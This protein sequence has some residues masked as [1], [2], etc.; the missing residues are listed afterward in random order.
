MNLICCEAFWKLLQTNKDKTVGDII[1]L[2]LDSA[3]SRLNQKINEVL[4]DLF[5]VENRRRFVRDN[6]FYFLR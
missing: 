1:Q 2:T 6:I 5:S 3:L 4:D